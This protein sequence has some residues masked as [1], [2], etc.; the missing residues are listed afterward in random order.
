MP[1]PPRQR[2]GEHYCNL[3]SVSSLSTCGHERFGGLKKTCTNGCLEETELDRLILAKIEKRSSIAK[4]PGNPGLAAIERGTDSTEAEVKSVQ[5]GGIRNCCECR[6]LPHSVDY[7]AN[8]GHLGKHPNRGYF[9]LSE[10][11]EISQK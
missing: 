10:L 6:C 5:E 1:P 2:G 8:D 4:G 7:E 11:S 3:S 9:A